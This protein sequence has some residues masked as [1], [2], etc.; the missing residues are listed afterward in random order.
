M[1]PS[2]FPTPLKLNLKLEKPLSE[3]VCEVLKLMG[4]SYYLHDPDEHVKLVWKASLPHYCE[5]N[6]PQ[7]DQP[8]RLIRF[9]AFILD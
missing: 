5:C 1:S 8:D 3:K 6:E 9:L 2:D 4:C 7:V